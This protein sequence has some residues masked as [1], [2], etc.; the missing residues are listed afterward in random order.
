M[1]NLISVNKAKY[2][3]ALCT[4]AILVSLNAIAAS[5]ITADEVK[6]LRISESVEILL[7]ASAT[8]LEEKQAV[9]QGYTQVMSTLIR[10]CDPVWGHSN[11]FDVVSMNEEKNIQNSKSYVIKI[12]ISGLCTRYLKAIHSKPEL[13]N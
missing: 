10:K 6:Y 8:E 4:G 1:K 12:S 9:D 13:N 11:L 5:S 2:I 3:L 7:N